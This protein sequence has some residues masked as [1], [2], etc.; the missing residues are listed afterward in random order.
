[1]AS[2]PNT[3][4]PNKLHTKKMRAP[5]VKTLTQSLNLTSAQARLIRALI[6]GEQKT[7]DA[8]RFPKSNAWFESCYHLP[9]RI[10]RI[11]ACID[12]VMQGHG[13]EAIDA[14]GIHLR[15]VYV[16]TGDM[17]APTLFYCYRARSYRVQ[18]WYGYVEA[19]GL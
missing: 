15:A 2:K 12:E 1:M 18:S 9:N 16:N 5:S 10:E 19:S 3:N 13:V 7:L 14:Q 11:M 17:Y 8:S 4:K 6:K